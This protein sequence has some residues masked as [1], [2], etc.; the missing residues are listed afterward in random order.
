MKYFMALGIAVIPSIVLAADSDLEYPKLTQQQLR[1]G[2]FGYLRNCVKQRT[3]RA[4][5][6]VRGFTRGSAGEFSAR[7]TA[8]RRARERELASKSYSFLVVQ[9][10][11][12]NECL[13][14]RGNEVIWV[15]GIGTKAIVDGRYY[16][17]PG[18][19]KIS[20]TKKYT[21]ASGTSKTVL[22]AETHVPTPEDQE[23]IQRQYEE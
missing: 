3:G 8:D 12:K 7:I 13:I 16:G 18:L 19:F 22:V 1:I 11:S 10:I 2:Q 14:E 21:T 4:P 5:V 17:F 15:K 20:G 23:A 9:V 6:G